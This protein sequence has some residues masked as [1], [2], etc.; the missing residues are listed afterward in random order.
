MNPSSNNDSYAHAGNWLTGTARRNPEGLLLLA[1]GCALLMRSGR[2]NGSSLGN[3]ARNM[4]GEAGR[5]LPN[6]SDATSGLR[7]GLSDTAE[8]A[9]DYASDLKDKASDVAGSYADTVSSFAGNAG[10]AVAD[11]SDRIRRQAQ[12]ALQTT[13]DRMLREQPLA[14]AMLGVAAG[15]AVAAAFP[16]TEVENRVLG[17]AHEAL[18]DAVDQASKSVMGAASKAGER[19]KTAATDRGLTSD[20]LKDLA[21]EVVGSFTDAVTGKSESKSEN[22]GAQSS[23]SG[24]SSQRNPSGQASPSSSQGSADGTGSSKG[25]ASSGSYSK[26][27]T[28]WPP[29]GGSR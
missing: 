15:A 7:K 6:M 3:A 19:L 13:M 18:S 8:M 25:N 10:R 21:G 14:V 22:K 5:N 12:G 24:Q 27:A 17:G 23:Q 28:S 20:G 26:P 9:S 2:G 11:G 1:A 29:A 16:A 4:V